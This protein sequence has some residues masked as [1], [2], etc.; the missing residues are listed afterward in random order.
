MNYLKEDVEFRTYQS[1]I[2][3]SVL[4]LGNTFVVLKTGKGKTHIFLYV[5]N[6]MADKGKIL[7]L[8]YSNPLADQHFETIKKNLIIDK[9]QLMT[10]RQKPEKRK[11]LWQEQQIFVA[12]PQ[13]FFFDL[14]KGFINL[15]D[16]SFICFDEADLASGKYAYTLI[17]DKIRGKDILV[18]AMTAS[19][20]RSENSER[21]NQLFEIVNIQIRTDEDQDLQPY[22]TE[23]KRKFVKGLLSSDFAE[24][25]DLII[26]KI[27]DVE[28]VFHFTGLLNTS[29]K[30][31]F[32]WQ[33][34]E[35]YETEGLW[36]NQRVEQQKAD[37]LS[38]SSAQNV[39]E[40]NTFK[41]LTDKQIKQLEKDVKDVQKGKE[42]YTYEELKKRYRLLAMNPR[43]GPEKR[44]IRLCQAALTLSEKDLKYIWSSIFE[45]R[46][47]LHLVKYF[48]TY[49]YFS[50]LNYI[51]EMEKQCSGKNKNWAAERIVCDQRIIKVK[52]FLENQLAQGKEHPKINVL[53]DV[54]EFERHAQRIILFCERVEVCRQL[55]QI[56]CQQCTCT[57]LPFLGTKHMAAKKRKNTLEKFK[58]KEAN[59]LICTSAAERGIDLSEVDC[60]IV[61]D[62]AASAL[63]TIQREGRLRKDGDIIQMMSSFVYR[64]GIG[65]PLTF[66]E[67]YFQ[68][69][70]K[71]KNAMERDV[72]KKSAQ[73]KEP[74][75]EQLA[76]AF[77]K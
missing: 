33:L 28:A 65:K 14:E 46:K 43:S 1:S 23:I 45:Y 59:I 62:P 77:D 39:Q 71:S 36:I 7:I 60:V 51:N 12:T 10:G 34:E 2:G 66:D 58:N 42:I 3:Q 52:E 32:Q 4:E 49:S 27:K 67:L 44:K 5:A 50:T 68:I 70:M 48:Q 61:Y 37:Q 64:E 54:L 29:V 75:Y 72:K 76:L 9:V 47:L 30:I 38:D 69:S 19:P 18:L 22:K 63:R 35:L 55:A 26:E 53:T 11:E 57:A 74:K 15:D 8:S 13:T 56:I 16:Y 31:L 6:Q 17:A 25:H 40:M 73:K 21:L 41:F 24:I 20:G